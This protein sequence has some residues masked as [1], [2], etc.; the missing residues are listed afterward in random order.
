MTLSR[1]GSDESVS[2][3]EIESSRTSLD[4][5]PRS[6]ER[7]EVLVERLI[8]ASLAPSTDDDD[9]GVEDEDDEVEVEVDVEGLGG[10]EAAFLALLSLEP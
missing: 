10:G 1:N 6:G 8:S 5:L 3:S 7:A 9:D 4:A 2:I